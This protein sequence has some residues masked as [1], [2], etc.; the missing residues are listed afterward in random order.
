MSVE[1]DVE[2]DLKAADHAR[3]DYALSIIRY[4]KACHIGYQS[5]AEGLRQ[6]AIGQLE[7]FMDCL[8]AAH[9]RLRQEEKKDGQ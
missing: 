7:A 6:V 3:R 5:R 9:A 1:D 4:E 8:W 2:R